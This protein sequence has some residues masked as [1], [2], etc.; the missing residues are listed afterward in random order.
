MA[1]LRADGKFLEVVRVVEQVR[2]VFPS[3]QLLVTRPAP[4]LAQERD[5]VLHGPRSTADERHPVDAGSRAFDR[6][7]RDCLSPRRT[8][9]ASGLRRI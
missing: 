4:D 5:F 7:A 1:V 6:P 8:D 9:Q 2:E 3:G